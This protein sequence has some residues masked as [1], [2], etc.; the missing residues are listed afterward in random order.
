MDIPKTNNVMIDRLNVMLNIMVREG[1]S[2]I[3]LRSEHKPY[4]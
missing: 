1:A 4:L 3:Y 2:D